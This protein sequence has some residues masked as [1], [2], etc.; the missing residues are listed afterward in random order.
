MK[1][2]KYIPE[3]R[4]PEFVGE[5]K[6]TIFGDIATFSKGKGISKDDIAIDGQTECIRYGELYTTYSEVI[7]KIAS[8]TNVDTANLV[9]SE[10]NDVIIPSSGETQI[11]IAT[12]SCVLKSGVALSGDLTI[13]KSNIN[14][15]FLSY[16]LNNAKKK[17]I[18]SMAQGISVVHLYSSQLRTLELNIPSLPEQTRIAS[19]LTT[20]DQRINL[21]TQQKEA[22]EL[23]KKGVMQ[24]LFP[25]T[26][27]GGK[28]Q[29]R[30]K[31]ENGNDFPDW[32]EKRLG[33]IAHIIMGQSPDSKNYNSSGIG[34]PLIQGNADILN[35]FSN[36]RNWTTQVTKECKIGDLILAVRAPVGI[37]SKSVHK[38]CIGRGVCAIRNTSKSN[39]EF[40]Y[41]FLLSYEPKWIRLEQGSTFTAIS[42][43]DIK[44]VE[45]SLPCIE[46]QQKIASFLSS[47]DAKI[48]QVSQQIEQSKTWKKGLLQK[49][50]V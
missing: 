21:L 18:A 4:F 12:A 25:S 5:W 22:L 24:Q 48:E 35:R 20:V 33:E 29:L 42:G 14:G 41:Q 37:I 15:V 36:P 2:S 49:M 26:G 47:I 31:D 34:I 1:E 9:F 11:D 39:M 19:F 13:I 32:E 10:E 45:I 16:Y 43:S 46:E 6:K 40:L 38:A 23:Y 44:S 50:F 17:E 30:F 28:P 8:K 27:S 7:D 3:L